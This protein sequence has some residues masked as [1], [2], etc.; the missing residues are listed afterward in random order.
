MRSVISSAIV[1]L[2]YRTSSESA[3]VSVAG[4]NVRVPEGKRC[5]SIGPRPLTGGPTVI[6]EASTA[7]DT[8]PAQPSG[9]TSSTV[10]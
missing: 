10:P 5:S 6:K 3:S 9:E 8:G 4:S 2:E 1:P 7:I